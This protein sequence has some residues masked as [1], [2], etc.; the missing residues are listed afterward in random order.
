MPFLRLY[1][2]QASAKPDVQHSN[3]FDILPVV[4]FN[5]EIRPRPFL[6]FVQS[7]PFPLFFNI[8]DPFL[9]KKF[10]VGIQKSVELTPLSLIQVTFFS[11]KFR[12]GVPLN[13]QNSVNFQQFLMEL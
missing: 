12:P 4:F 6:L 2:V 1:F 7:S 11:G 3:S 8:Q 10:P 9:E 13:G 5:N